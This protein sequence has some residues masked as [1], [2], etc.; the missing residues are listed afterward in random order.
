MLLRRAALLLLAVA[1]SILVLG[2]PAIARTS[3]PDDD[4]GGKRCRTQKPQRFLERP[5]YIVGGSMVPKRHDKAIR[6]RTEEYGYV[7]G[8]GSSKWNDHPP[9]YYAASTTF[10]D[11][12]L[13]VHKKIVPALRCVERDIKAKCK[14]DDYTADS[15]SGFR[16]RNTYR[17]GEI[18]NHLYGIAIDIDPHKNPCCHCVEPWSSDPLCQKEV[19]SP[20]ERAA[21]PACWIKSFERHG[22]YWLGHD[23]LEDTMH[24]EFLG[25]PERVLR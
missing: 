18:T 5:H 6:Y 1:S 16:D 11:H 14:K 15:V 17:G 9:S 25:R 24:F 23:E 13:S 3:D 20:Y 2:T 19:K 12:T 21:I 7:E 4:D 22:F 8:F 10:F